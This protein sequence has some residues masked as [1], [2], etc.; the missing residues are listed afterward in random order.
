MVKGNAFGYAL[1]MDFFFFPEKVSCW[2]DTKYGVTEK[3]SKSVKTKAQRL[4]QCAVHNWRI[5]SKH[6]GSK[7][8]HMRRPVQKAD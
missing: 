4:K 1:K 7:S 8:E 3:M 5:V 2:L 6:K